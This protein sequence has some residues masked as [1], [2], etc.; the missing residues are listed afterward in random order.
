MRWGR[1]EKNSLG[2]EKRRG[3]DTVSVCVCK[4][5]CY[6]LSCLY[7]IPPSFSLF[8]S[9]TTPAILTPTHLPNNRLSPPK[10]RR[11]SMPFFFLL[12]AGGVCVVGLVRFGLV[13]SGWGCSMGGM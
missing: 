9:Q 2:T 11:I 6:S 10:K 1:Y 12:I 7:P 3:L 4:C 8:P 5:V 13:W